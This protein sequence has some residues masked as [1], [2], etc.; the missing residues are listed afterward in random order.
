MG[1]RMLVAGGDGDPTGSG[2][3]DTVS[4]RYHEVCHISCIIFGAKNLTREEVRG[5]SVIELGSYDMNGSL[6]PLLES[7]GPAEY[8]GVD[9]VEGS[10]VDVVCRAEDIVEKFGKERFDI[11]ISTELLEHVRDWRLVVSN[12]KNICRPEGIILITTRSPGYEYHATP[13][14]YWRYEP[15]DMRRIFSDCEELVVEKD[16]QMPGVFAKFRKP[17]DLVEKDLS[18]YELFSIVVNG[19]TREI[20]EHDLKNFSFR[21]R[22]FKI[23]FRDFVFRSLRFVFSRF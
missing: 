12:I 4:R 14:D 9:I 15:D 8:V 17:V 19:R 18:D 21:T 20:S 13:H 22:V 5:K 1:P 6:R 16:Y 23:R 10:G 7:W 3:P 2:F 11:V